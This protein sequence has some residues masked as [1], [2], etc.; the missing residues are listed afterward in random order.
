MSRKFV[1]HRFKAKE[2][3]FFAVLFPIVLESLMCY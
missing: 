2:V 3:I 1:K